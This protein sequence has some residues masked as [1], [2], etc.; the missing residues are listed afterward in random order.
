[1]KR[2]REIQIIE[3][4]TSEVKERF[5]VTLW[6]ELDIVKKQSEIE[7]NP[8]FDHSNF[9]VVL[10]EIEPEETQKEDQFILPV[11]FEKL[12]D[13]AD[14]SNAL[15]F[16][17]GEMTDEK[18]MFVRKLRKQSGVLLFKTTETISEEDQ[19]AINGIKPTW[20]NKSAA[21]KQRAVMY[22]VWEIKPEGYR[23]FN[24]YYAFKMEQLRGK[25]LTR[26][27]EI[28]NGVGV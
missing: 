23:E 27:E 4:K 5:E 20:E 3:I 21:Q 26:L 24:Q 9:N 18:Y 13:R 2:E 25:M 8:K 17:S 16:N 14:N 6:S 7:E 12:T 15:V 19:E 11:V 10:V 22:R 28:K 1:M